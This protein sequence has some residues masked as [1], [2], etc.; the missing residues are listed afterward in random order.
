MEIFNA[1]QAILW[2]ADIANKFICATVDE[3]LLSAAFLEN[4]RLPL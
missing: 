2:Y 3:K 4:C 1:M